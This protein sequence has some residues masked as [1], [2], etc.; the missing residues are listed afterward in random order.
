M[1]N[2]LKR[3]IDLAKKLEFIINIGRLTQKAQTAHGQSCGTSEKFARAA[4]KFTAWLIFPTGII[5]ALS[6]LSLFPARGKVIKLANL[7][8]ANHPKHQ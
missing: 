7:D 6:H 4:P 5:A 2:R 3:A 8:G 1:L